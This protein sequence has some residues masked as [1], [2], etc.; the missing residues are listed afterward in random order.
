[1]N[2]KS[3]NKL[4]ISIFTLSV[5]AGFISCSKNSSSYNT[6]VMREAPVATAAKKLV[7]ASGYADD[8]FVT[9]DYAVAEESKAN[10]VFEPAEFNYERKLIKTGNLYLEVSSLSDVDKTISEFASTYKGYVTDSSMYENHFNATVRIPSANFEQAMN[11]AGDLGKVKSRSVNSQ[12]VSEEFYDLQTRLDTKKTM[13]KK[14]ESYLSNAKD[15][16]DLLEIERQL[17]SVTTEIESMEGR[18]KRLSNQIDYSTIYIG[19]TLPLGFDESGFDWPDLGESFR[20]FGCNIVNFGAGL[21]IFLFYLVVYGIPI[22][23]IAAFFFWLLFGRVG[24]LVK[25]FK[26]LKNKK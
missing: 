24:L 13:Q 19:M 11:S 23:A 12:D 7:A 2:V 14:L 21:L 17:N 8:S 5:M 9:A 16:K 20:K 22:I 6:S 1:M 25:L 3:I 15:I 26:R 18:M 4:F 10:G